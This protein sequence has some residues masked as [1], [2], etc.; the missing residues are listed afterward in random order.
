[1]FGVK[2]IDLVYLGSQD[3][4]KHQRDQSRATKS[5]VVTNPCHHSFFNALVVWSKVRNE[6]STDAG[7]KANVIFPLSVVSKDVTDLSPQT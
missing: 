7:P 2:D 6:N 1:M 5:N 3:R 4:V